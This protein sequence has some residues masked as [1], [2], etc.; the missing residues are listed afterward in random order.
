MKNQINLPIYMRRKYRVK[1]VLNNVS[2]PEVKQ[3]KTI[4]DMGS[5]NNSKKI[6]LIRKSLGGDV[7]LDTSIENVLSPINDPLFKHQIHESLIPNS[8]NNN[9]IENKIKLESKYNF[10]NKAKETDFDRKSTLQQANFSKMP[11]I[12]SHNTQNITN[13]RIKKYKWDLNSSR[14]KRNSQIDEDRI[15]DATQDEI[16]N[17]FDQTSKRIENIKKENDSQTSKLPLTMK[18]IFTNNFRCLLNFDK[19]KKFWKRQMEFQSSNASNSVMNRG[20]FY[21]EKKETLND[22]ETKFYNPYKYV[23]A[24][25]VQGLRNSQKEKYFIPVGSNYTRLYSFVNYSP[26]NRKCMEKIRYPLDKNEFTLK[27]YKNSKYFLNKLKLLYP[28][29]H[30]KK[31]QND[32]DNLNKMS[33]EG[34]NKFQEELNSFKKLSPKINFSLKI[35]PLERDRNEEIIAQQYDLKSK[36]YN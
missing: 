3:D 18:N 35:T 28:E 20:Q 6:Y 22:L 26:F 15:V 33:I 7:S 31:I 25:F 5:K 17:I 9:S 23:N 14:I 30:L 12:E 27:S 34:V 16:Q 2:L 8:V 24:S 36:F 29:N 21:I 13:C 19:Y 11:T 32:T 1:K 4:N 10:M